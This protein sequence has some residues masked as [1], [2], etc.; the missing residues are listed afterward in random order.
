MST[1][2][3][4]AEKELFAATFGDEP[5]SCEYIYLIHAALPSHCPNWLQGWVAEKLVDWEEGGDDDRWKVD[6][7]IEHWKMTKTIIN[8]RFH[9][10]QPDVLQETH[11]ALHY[12]LDFKWPRDQAQDK[13]EEIERAKNDLPQEDQNRIEHSMW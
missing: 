11:D 1:S 9:C 12:L 6:T 10:P 7:V 5:L 3:E 13:Y 4:D 2:R 8:G